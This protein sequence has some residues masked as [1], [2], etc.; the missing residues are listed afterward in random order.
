MLL[1]VKAVQLQTAQSQSELLVAGE[2]CEE[3]S[4]ECTQLEDISTLSRTT[5]NASRMTEEGIGYST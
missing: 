3:T 1:I 2:E 5:S 4:E